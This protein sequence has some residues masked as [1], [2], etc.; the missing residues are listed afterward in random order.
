MNA[1]AP[2]Q[3]VGL[4]DPSG[5]YEGIQGYLKLSASIVP[6]GEALVGPSAPH[7]PP[8]KAIDC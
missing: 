3:W 8:Q 2:G 1:D 7:R 4:T 6:A 5:E